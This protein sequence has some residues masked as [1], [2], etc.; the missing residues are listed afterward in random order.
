M[1]ANQINYANYVEKQRSNLANELEANRHN[2]VWEGETNR[3][4]VV[5]ENETERHNRSTESIN[6][7]S[8]R[9]MAGYHAGQ[10]ANQQAA[11]AET[12]RTNLAKE[13]ETSRH[14]YVSEVN[15]VNDSL[16]RFEASMYGSETAMKTGM[17][18]LGGNT[19]GTLAKSLVEWGK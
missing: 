2:I 17:L 10:L 6:W 1:T 11:N 12:H 14:N 13:Q 16:N 4:N 19:L 9:E 5:S 18:S 15:D 3:H 7:Y 8:A